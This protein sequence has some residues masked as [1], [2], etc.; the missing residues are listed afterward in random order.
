MTIQL[1][2]KEGLKVP[3]FD[4]VWVWS[5]WSLHAV[6]VFSVVS[7]IEL[8]V[9][10]PHQEVLGRGCT[11]SDDPSQKSNDL[12]GVLKLCK[13]WQNFT[14]N[15][16][17]SLSFSFKKNTNVNCSTYYIWPWTSNMGELE[18]TWLGGGEW[19]SM[20]T[21]QLR[22]CVVDPKHNEY[23]QH[24]DEHPRG[25][26]SEKNPIVYSRQLPCFHIMKK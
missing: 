17:W 13:T 11:S 18:S 7:C 8:I 5:K 6:C 4:H 22:S 14:V 12:I 3:W 21:K 9:F 10:H 15:L 20:V 26:D 24:H 1:N 2:P 25:P 16:I 19:I 23:G